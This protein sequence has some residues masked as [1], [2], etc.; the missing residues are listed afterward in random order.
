MDK[1]LP[2]VE[3]TKWQGN[4]SLATVQQYAHH[5]TGQCGKTHRVI[6]LFLNQ[7]IGLLHTVA[8]LLAGSVFKVM[9]FVLRAIQ[10][11]LQFFALGTGFFHAAF[12]II[13]GQSFHISQHRAYFFHQSFFL[14]FKIAFHGIFPFIWNLKNPPKQAGLTQ[15]IGIRLPIA[16]AIGLS[17][18][19]PPYLFH[20]NH[21]LAK[22][23]INAPP[24][25]NSQNT[26]PFLRAFGQKI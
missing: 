15:H 9:Q 25:A 12:H 18:H 26:I 10:L 23:Y 1:T 4:K 16:S 11:I 17:L 19:K 7:L 14:C 3:I 2:F 21:N 8:N 5:Q 13:F 24:M 22:T 20:G 6:R